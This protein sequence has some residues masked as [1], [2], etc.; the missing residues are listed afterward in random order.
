MGTT[1]TKF[2]QLESDKIIETVKALHDRIEERFPRSGL[3]KVVGELQQV[4]EETVGRTRWIQKPHLPLRCAAALLSLGIIV[5]L[6]FLVAHVRQFNFED[7]TNSVQALDSSIGSVVF[8]GAAILFFLSW[9]HRIKRDRAL[10]AIHELRALAHIVDMHQL[11]KDP[12]SLFGSGQHTT[13]FRKRAMTP[14]ELN[15][16]LDYC[17]D[18][19]ALISKIAA[20]YV[21]GF[22]DPVLLDAVDDVEDLT[23]GFSRKIWQKITILEN[24]RRALHGGPAAESAEPSRKADSDLA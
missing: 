21:Q 22:Q 16:Y 9:E 13:R 20:L 18:A 3:G 1:S 8:V 15:R 11:T 12:E 23:A 4:A 14:F 2:R 24:L 7:F 5:L 6:A 19:L 17:S 10:K